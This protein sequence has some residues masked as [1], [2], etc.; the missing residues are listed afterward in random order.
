MKIFQRPALHNV[1][2]DAALAEARKLIGR[3]VEQPARR[4][5]LQRSLT[6]GGLSLLTGCSISDNAGVEAALSTISR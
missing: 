1:D 3:E 4:A 6:M 5:F 2:A